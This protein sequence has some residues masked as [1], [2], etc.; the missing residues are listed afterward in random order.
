MSCS[1]F[2]REEHHLYDQ[3]L[4][5]VGGPGMTCA[6]PRKPAGHRRA[7]KG[8]R[9]MELAFRILFKLAFCLVAEAQKLSGS[10]IT[11]ELC[12]LL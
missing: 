5:I 7:H 4:S 6:I 2:S 9:D 10:D 11:Q 1:N 12:L 3:R 8:R